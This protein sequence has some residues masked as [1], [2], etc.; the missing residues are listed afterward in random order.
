MNVMNEKLLR[1]G[2]QNSHVANQGDNMYD[3]M[4]ALF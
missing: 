4:I 1:S 2:E 3:T